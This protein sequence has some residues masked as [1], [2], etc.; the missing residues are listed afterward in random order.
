MKKFFRVL[1]AVVIAAVLFGCSNDDSDGS[2]VPEQKSVAELIS[3]AKAG[4]TV[5]LT[6]GTLAENASLSVDKA[7]VLTGG[8]TQFDAK[9]AV[10]TVSA[11][12]V[13]LKN[14]KNIKAVTVAE[15]VGD[16][17]FTLDNCD[18]AKLTVNGGGSNSIHLKGSNVA[19]LNAA[20]ENVRIVLEKVCRIL[21][22]AVQKNCQIEALE[23]Q[24]LV[25][26]VVVDKAVKEVTLSGKTTITTLVTKSEA[27]ATAEEKTKIIVSS[28]AITISKAANTAEE[29][30]TVTVS[31]ITQEVASAEIEKVS[32]ET[33]TKDEVTQ[34]EEKVKE[35]EE[36][37]A[38]EKVEEII[39]ES[40]TPVV[41]ID[42]EGSLSLQASPNGV[43]IKATVPAK[44]RQVNFYRA[45]YDK[46]KYD[47]DPASQNWEYI[48]LYQTNSNAP[49][50]GTISYTD[51]YVES[52]K[53]Y[54]YCAVGLSSANGHI[55][56]KSEIDTITTTAGHGILQLPGAITLN[57]QK[58]G[59]VFSA[60]GYQTI[61]NFHDAEAVARLT[62]YL[63]LEGSIQP[64]TPVES[65]VCTTLQFPVADNMQ[66][67][68]FGF[69]NTEHI[70]KPLVAV[71]AKVSLTVTSGDVEC[72][73]SSIPTELKGGTG[74]A[75]GKIT[76]TQ[77]ELPFKVEDAATGVTIT[78][79][80]SKLSAKEKVVRI[81]LQ[82]DRDYDKGHVYI[83]PRSS[84]TEDGQ[85]LV[86]YESMPYSFTESAVDANTSNKISVQ[87]R[88][89]VRERTGTNSYRTTYTTF[90]N[91]AIVDYKPKAGNGS[92]A[93]SDN[94]KIDYDTYSQTGLI[95]SDAS[96]WFTNGFAFPESLS[97]TVNGESVALPQ[98]SSVVPR[99][100]FKDKDAYTTNAAFTGFWRYK[101]NSDIKDD[102]EFVYA[103]NLFYRLNSELGKTV[104]PYR[105]QI[106]AQYRDTS[107]G[108]GLYLYYYPYDS[109]MT[110]VS[111]FP[112]S[113]TVKDIYTDKTYEIVDSGDITGTITFSDV[114]AT[115]ATV[116]LKTKEAK[117]QYYAA[118]SDGTVL[119]RVAPVEM[120]GTAYLWRNEI[121]IRDYPYW[122]E[123]SYFTMPS[124]TTIKLCNAWFRDDSN[125]KLE[126]SLHPSPY[127]SE[128]DASG[129]VSLEVYYNGGEVNWCKWSIEGDTDYVTFDTAVQ[130]GS[131]KKL[132]GKN[133]TS[134]DKK[135]TV[136]VEAYNLLQKAEATKEFTIK[137]KPAETKPTE[138][139]YWDFSSLASVA[140]QGVY[141]DPAL[142]SSAELENATVV[143]TSF[144]G[145]NEKKFSIK[146]DV[147]YWATS[148]SGIMTIKAL[149]ESSV[150]IQ[151]NKYEKEKTMG[152]GSAG[153]LQ[154]RKD[155]VVIEKM[156][157]PFTI[158]MVY[159]SNGGSAKTDRH[160][161][162]KVAGK[163]AKEG[164]DYIPTDSDTL[165]YAYTG[166][167]AVDVVIGA[168]NLV[169]LYDVKITRY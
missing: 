56:G 26:S 45:E 24:S 95:T 50:Q 41:Y 164:N 134:E 83:Y 131:S 49:L 143:Y 37:A 110:P 160:A 76:F 64:S 115:R 8:T 103:D 75:D 12:G 55:T 113:V 74:F 100:T 107:T 169:R 111:G 125:E 101:D 98:Y 31:E 158:E 166:T 112:E 54:S 57:Y 23:A 119:E 66:C 18:V 85:H 117:K 146:E 1:S 87:F 155:A 121:C 5:T 60:E 88:D 136:K 61:S 93:L 153:C 168:T 32:Y 63:G 43:L 135:V 151:Y 102:E 148:G 40:E 84:V 15:A 68:S 46:T 52:G 65:N 80:P 73:W 86:A 116:T 126:I 79:D 21:S 140:C 145:T 30:G 120:T 154:I 70:G 162:I 157:G 9:G 124:P 25:E 139:I 62:A 144:G 78:A 48:G 4:D 89:A 44:T 38:T 72:S 147:S 114:T 104:S 47:A 71:G 59:F 132:I 20:Y 149:D 163:T 13:T 108:N 19:V 150:P 106:Y 11:K 96:T 36:K 129:E 109:T 133:D 53:S 105:T 34:T 42:N 82:I 128:I 138:T 165:S 130:G 27:S 142:E 69:P 91:V 81:D 161:Y 58:D 2:D 7:I 35:I 156:Q 10:I 67:S 159:G 99:V 152:S 33:L 39:K 77:E 92:P 127:V 97:L 167:D 16:G 137:R 141:A 122:L 22:M 51:Y 94:F 6:Q 3:F 17:D 29:N 90:F 14:I 123:T 28:N 118:E